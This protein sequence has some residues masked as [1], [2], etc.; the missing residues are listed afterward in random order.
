MLCIALTPM[1]LLQGLTVVP[2]AIMRRNMTF[3][4]LAIRTLIATVI[5]G[6]VGIWPGLAG[7]QAWALV[8]QQLVTGV[9]GAVVLWTVTDWRPRLRLPRQAIKDLWGFSPSP[10]SAASACSCD[11]H[12]PA[13]DR[14]VLRAGRGRPVPHRAAPARHAHRGDQQVAA[15]GVAAGVGPAAAPTGRTGRPAGQDAARVRRDG[16]AGAG[17]PRRHRETARRAARPGM[18]AGRHRHAAAVHRRRSSTCTGCCSARRC[19]RSGGPASTPHCHGSSSPS[20]S[21]RSTSSG[22]GCTAPPTTGRRSPRSRW[23]C[24]RSSCRS[25]S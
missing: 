10:R 22:S 5:G 3:R 17:H 24:P 18:V 9:V 7:Y 1:I 20:A 13:G 14:Q 23:A 4:P 8:A 25:R 12:G 16:A 2:E 19:R 11:P 15:A 6:V 21:P